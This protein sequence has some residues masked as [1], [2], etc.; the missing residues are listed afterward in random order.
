MIST[1][2]LQEVMV[3]QIIN[4]EI[5]QVV[6]AI[7]IINQEIKQMI[8]MITMKLKMTLLRMIKI[9]LN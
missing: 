7:Q 5:H 2:I 8:T 9:N 4:T 1:E 6:M 3:I